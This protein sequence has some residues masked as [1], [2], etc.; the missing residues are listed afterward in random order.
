MVT[1]NG[2]HRR[3]FYIGVSVLMGIIAIAGF[4]PTYFGPLVGGTIEQP[5]I[6]HF[7]ALVFSGWLLLFLTQAV[8]AATGRVSWHVRLGRIGIGYGVLLIIVGLFTGISRSAD[9]LSAGGMRR[10]Y[11]SQ[12]LP[13]WPCFRPSSQPPSPFGESLKSTSA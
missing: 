12:R 5:P 1:I 6:I 13:T 2:L 3:R 10:G 9:R 4:W 11:S 7:H 8:L